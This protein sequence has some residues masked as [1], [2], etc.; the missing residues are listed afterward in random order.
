MRR[1][2]LAGLLIFAVAFA[3]RWWLLCGLILGDDGQEFGVLQQVLASGPDFR[4]Q[5]Q[6]RFGGWLFNWLSAL[7]LGTSETTVLL[8]TWILSS[9]FGVLA[10]ALLVR[11]G[12][13]PG[14]ALAGGLLVATAPFEVV[15]GTLRTNDLYLAGAFAVAFTAVALLED[16]P[17]RQGVVHQ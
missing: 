2:L 11:W 4:D 9:L 17:V 5:L 16:R 7:L 1:P 13:P 3:L 12:Y 6:V 14:R 15:L 8:P 10:R